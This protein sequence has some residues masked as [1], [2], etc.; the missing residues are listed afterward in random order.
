M[1]AKYNNSLKRRAP[2]TGSRL[3]RV[4]QDAVARL[5]GP[6]SPPL[7]LAPVPAGRPNLAERGRG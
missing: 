1:P 6:N 7:A 2:G 4:L 3:F 5:I